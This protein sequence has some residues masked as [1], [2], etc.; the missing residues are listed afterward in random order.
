MVNGTRKETLEGTPQGG[1]ISPALCNIALNGLQ[2][3]IRKIYPSLKRIKGET[4]KVQMVRYADDLVITGTSK[5]ILKN[6][7]TTIQ[8]FL[9]ERGLTT[10]TSKTRIV[11]ANQGFNFLGF[12][13]K[14]RKHNPKLNNTKK[15]KARV[16]ALV[17]RP[18]KDKIDA[19]KEKIR[20]IID[21]N[22]PIET[23]ARDLNPVLRGWAE[24]FRVSYHSIEVMITLGHYVHTKI[25]K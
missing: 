23:I 6:V 13:I 12:E 5:E 25:W 8:N 18:T 11:N 19:L 2:E 9:A 4:C 7:L 1:V 3:E 21:P 17:I 14:R 22:K 16:E 20:E 15:D 10:K 24:Y